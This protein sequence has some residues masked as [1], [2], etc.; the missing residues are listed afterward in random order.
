[1]ERPV[2]SVCY[3]MGARVSR[4][5]ESSRALPMFLIVV[6]LFTYF[7]FQKQPWVNN[8]EW[9]RITF[10]GEPK[11]ISAAGNWQVVRAIILDSKAKNQ[12]IPRKATRG[13][14]NF[15]TD[16]RVNFEFGR[17]KDSTLAISGAYRQR[18]A[19]MAL[20]GLRSSPPEAIPKQMV[21]KVG[22][23]GDDELVIAVGTAQSIYLARR[24][25]GD[26]A[27]PLSLFETRNGRTTKIE[28]K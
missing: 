18:G 2:H 9:V 8:W 12:L 11:T 17:H 20:S 3:A 10:M 14:V 5:R 24:Q 28:H 23:S 1:M 21:L 16:G 4:Y 6:G 26:K 15:S 13:S 27:L 22:W 7:V 19:N 25:P